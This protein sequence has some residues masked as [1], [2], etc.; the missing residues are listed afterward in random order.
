M[1]ISVKRANA[2]RR[3]IFA[4]AATTTTASRSC[5]RYKFGGPDAVTV[6]Y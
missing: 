3:S 1:Q 5:A 2:R 6:R 4:L